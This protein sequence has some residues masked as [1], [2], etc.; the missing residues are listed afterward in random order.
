M[1][2]GT[3]AVMA[4]PGHDERDFEFANK[5]NLEVKTVIKSINGKKGEMYDGEGILINSGP[6]T[7]TE[8]QIARDKIAIFIGA[9]KKV[10]YRMRD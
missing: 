4:V 7:N 9:K 2:Y 10:N 5:F 1:N 8:T 3:G 6:F